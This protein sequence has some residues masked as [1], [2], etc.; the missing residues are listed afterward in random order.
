MLALR[1]HSTP[2]NV[3]SKWDLGVAGSI[4]QSLKTLLLSMD[5]N[6]CNDTTYGL[7]SDVNVNLVNRIYSFLFV[8]FQESFS[9]HLGYT[10]LMS[11]NQSKT[12]TYS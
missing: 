11:T 3:S 6:H 9:F 10:V 5:H 7:D 4:G 8:R 1:F 12:V 2:G